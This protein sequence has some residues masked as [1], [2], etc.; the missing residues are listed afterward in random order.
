MR[1]LKMQWVSQQDNIMRHKSY[2]WYNHLIFRPFS[3]SHCWIHDSVMSNGSWN[4]IYLTFYRTIKVVNAK[5]AWAHSVNKMYFLQPF[6][7]MFNVCLWASI[8]GYFWSV[9]CIWEVNCLLILLRSPSA[10]QVQIPAIWECCG[11]K[12]VTIG[13]ENEN[14]TELFKKWWT[15]NWS[16]S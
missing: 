9:I 4:W 7:A 13:M 5:Y 8:W 16:V 11:F 6:T 1:S 12:D 10:L 14:V 3:D 2:G 15:G